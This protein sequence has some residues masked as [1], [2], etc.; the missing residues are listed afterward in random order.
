VTASA[1]GESLEHAPSATLSAT[2]SGLLRREPLKEVPAWG[3]KDT[4]LSTLGFSAVRAWLELAAEVVRRGRPEQRL[5]NAT[6]GGA[7]IEGFEELTLAEV[8]APLPEL[9]ITPESLASAA[10][11]ASP[12]LSAGEIAAWVEVQL[13][14]ARAT[15]AAARRVRRLTN[16]AGKA[17][18][19]ADPHATTRVFT[20]LEE[21]ERCLR[22]AVQSSPFV[23][24]FSWTAID[25]VM[26]EGDGPS[27]DNLESAEAGVK[28]EARIA[29]AIE[30]CT[31]ELETKLEQL[32]QSFGAPAP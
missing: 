19:S 3:G 5:I 9:G 24:A 1:D 28:K 12:P 11:A 29:S 15:R 27:H 25:A 2:N 21:A 7:R 17:M 23:D 4:A 30:T 22:A 8:L 26:L 31:R 14:G 6:E 10:R 20:K 32:L 16:A 13:S 18:R